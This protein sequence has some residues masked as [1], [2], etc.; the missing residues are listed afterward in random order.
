MSR[1]S[2]RFPVSPFCSPATQVAL[3]GLLVLTAAACGSGDPDNSAPE[4]TTDSLGTTTAP[5]SSTTPT[6]PNPSGITP[7][8]VDPT[9]PPVDPAASQTSTP[10][11]VPPPTGSVTPMPTSAQPQPNTT[12]PAQPSTEPDSSSMSPGNEDST[13]GTDTSEP[14]SPPGVEVGFHT[15]DGSLLDVNGNEFLMRGVNY[16]YAWYKDS[17]DTQ[18][19]F[20]EI[21][22]TGANAVRVVMATGQQW[23]RTSGAEVT[24]IINWAKA[25]KLVAMLEVHDATGYGDNTAPH[26]DHVLEYWLSSDVLAALAGQEAYVLVNIANEAFGN[27]ASDQWQAFHEM[28]VAEL[29]AGGLRHTLIVDAPFWGQ[30]WTNCMRDGHTDPQN[31]GYDFACDAQAVFDADPDRNTMF[32]THMYDVYGSSD[33]VRAYFDRFLGKGLPFLIGEFAADHGAGAD[34][35][36]DEASIME[37]S[38]QHGIGYLG[39]SWSG[40]GE[41]L[42]SLDITSAFTPS[43]LTTWGDRLINGDNGLA[44]TAVTCTCFD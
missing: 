36:V 7:Q 43:S 35:N 6:T 44:Q 3:A 2:H 5:S 40:N 37:L 21:A 22:A 34:K 42:E 4:N 11:V 25:N 8:P 26:P 32:S 38:A 1:T 27:D 10:P 9:P 29:R 24:N 33:I 17:Q 16:P 28:A 15:K 14:T 23:T 41:G 13:P 31:G 19:R 39:W 30:D 20:Q 18:Q 12:A